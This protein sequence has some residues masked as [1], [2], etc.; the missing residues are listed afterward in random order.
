MATTWAKKSDWQGPIKGDY[1]T[2]TK[3]AGL[4]VPP[5]GFIWS[6][7]YYTADLWRE[8]TGLSSFT[9]LAGTTVLANT[10]STKNGADTLTASGADYFIQNNS[11]KP[12]PPGSGMWKEVKLAVRFG[13]WTQQAI[14]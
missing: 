1:Q 4:P 12:N 5:T 10:L 8:G 7:E 14:P 6:R 9:S 11:V 13:E 2:A 3:V